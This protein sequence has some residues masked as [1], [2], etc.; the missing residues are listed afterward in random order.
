MPAK[1][2]FLV[3]HFWSY[4]GCALVWSEVHHCVCVLVLGPL[5][6]D[7]GVNQCQ[8]LPI[9]SLGLPV[10][11]YEAIPRIYLLLLGLG[12]CGRGQAATKASFHLLRACGQIS[13]CLKE[14]RGPP[15]TASCLLGCYWKSLL[16]C[17]SDM[18]LV[19]SEWCSSMIEI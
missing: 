15:L 13:K 7:S 5:G 3:C 1:I 9:T 6:T 19:L 12:V 18:I 11:N 14:P 2:S 4:L 17:M 8:M 16:R 10:W